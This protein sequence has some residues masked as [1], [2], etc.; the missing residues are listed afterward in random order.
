MSSGGFGYKIRGFRWPSITTVIIVVVVLILWSWTGSNGFCGNLCHADKPEYDAWKKST[1]A[2][3]DCVDCHK[4]GGRLSLVGNK[5]FSID[6]IVGTVYNTLSK[7]VPDKNLD[8]ALSD[9]IP[10]SVCLKCHSLNRITPSKGILINHEKHAKK[11]VN[12]TTCHNRVA[13][14]GLVEYDDFMMMRACYRCHGNDRTAIVML[15]CGSC[16]SQYFFPKTHKPLDFVTKQHAIMA[17]QDED[18]CL[19]CHT[20]QLCNDC[21]ARLGVG[22]ETEKAGPSAEVRGPKSQ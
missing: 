6:R 2:R 14:P 18:Y 10:S 8:S 11:N 12:C 19:M 13:H 21:H 20:K 16:H 5:V 15:P 3:A 17:R 1:H 4:V 7:N 22:A 9:S